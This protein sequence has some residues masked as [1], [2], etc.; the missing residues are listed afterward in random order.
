MAYVP[1]VDVICQAAK[2]FSFTD[3]ACGQMESHP[4]MVLAVFS[5]ASAFLRPVREDIELW[6]KRHSTAVWSKVKKTIKRSV[7]RIR[8]S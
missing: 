5:V 1:A 2:G 6:W 3:V 8:N 7:G 4:L